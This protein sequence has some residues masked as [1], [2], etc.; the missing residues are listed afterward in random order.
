MMVSA[1][2]TKSIIHVGFWSAVITAVFCILFS[3][4][5]VLTEA[6]AL[7]APWDVV[8]P[9][10]PSLVLAPAFLVML[11][12]VNAIVP[13]EKKIWIQL[14]VAFAEV[15]VPLCSTA[16][17]VEL[18]V[19]EPRVMHG[20]ASQV[21]LLT[22]TR[23]DTILNAVDGIGYIFM[24]LATLFAAPAFVGGRL[25]QWIRWLFLANGILAAPIFLTYFVN[26]SFIYVAAPWSV[27]ISGSAILLAIFFRRSG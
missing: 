13:S 19:V 10:A 24:C 18:F 23:G 20:A 11:V 15:Y 27:T 12:C 7:A 9:I 17:I 5:A 6:G 26:P 3:I 25:Q 16:Y 2:P 14:G 22:L 4:A 8:L 21:A 1:A